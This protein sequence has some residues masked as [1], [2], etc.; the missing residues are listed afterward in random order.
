MAFHH[1]HGTTTPGAPDEI[2]DWFATFE[3]WICDV[4]GWI[5]VSGAGTTDL[6]IRSV[7]EVGGLTMLFARI[8]SWPPNR[9]RVEVRDDA[10]G[11][12]E[13]TEAAHL[14]TGGVQFEYWMSADLDAFHLA[15]K[16][17]AGYMMAHAGL[18]MPFALTVVD[19]TY[20]SVCAA[21]LW[22]ARILRRHDNLWN[23]IDLLY[24]NV[25]IENAIRD[26]DDGSFTL[27]GVL[28]AD[29][30]DIAGQFRHI[31]SRFSGAGS[32]VAEDTIESGQPG[33]TTTWVV[34]ADPANRKYALRTGGVLP[35]G[36][37]DGA[38][39]AHTTGIAGTI[40]AWFAAL[41]AFMTGVGWAATDISGASG[42][43][44]DW[45][46]NSP[47]ESGVDDVWI[48][49]RHVGAPQPFYFTTADSAFGTPGRQE[50]LPGFGGG[51]A[52]ADFPQP[53]WFTADLDCLVETTRGAGG[54]YVPN[55]QGNVTPCAP[56]LSSTYMKSCIAYDLGAPGINARILEAHDGVWNQQVVTV[57]GGDG[58]HALLS[59]P[60]NYDGVTYLV[61]PAL[62]HHAGVGGG[63]EPIGQTRYYFG[64]DGG[65]VANLDTITVGA[66]VYTVFFDSN[67]NS[68][69]IRT[70]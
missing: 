49:C 2:V 61:W 29:L 31:S 55:W 53:Y 45:E 47:G 15:N 54:A 57:L 69:A 20:H 41:V 68:Y 17:G 66:R 58:A 22:N 14:D 59:Q 37:V 36:L 30:A 26:R 56:G 8:Y 7:G 5:R 42:N 33:G 4:V 6:V 9:I 21:D 27:A 40:A 10:V 64:T 18:L 13:T 60:N 16:I 32:P 38:H 52:P 65:G 3:A 34:L 48:R 19:E 24:Q 28:F 46:F 43:L 63:D 51:V 44:I 11:T 70:V 23:Q 67:G 62:I 25:D 12:H 50:T 39:F 35:T 1:L